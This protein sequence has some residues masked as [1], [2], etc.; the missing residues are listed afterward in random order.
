MSDYITIQTVG[1]DSEDKVLSYINARYLEKF[2]TVPPKSHTYIWARDHEEKVRGVIALD[3]ANKEGRVPIEE[4]YV[5][6]Y[7]SMERQTT[8]HDGVQFGRWLAEKEPSGVSMMLLYAAVCHAK[9]AGKRYGWV[10]HNDAVHRVLTRQGITFY[11]LPDAKLC[12]EKV[13]ELNR[14]YYL[15]PPLMKPYVM[16]LTEAEQVL[17]GTMTSPNCPAIFL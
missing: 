12:I 16:D 10:E 1:S 9:K 15:T 14:K 17:Q 11:P 4:L 13:A 6:D 7:A 2:G 8:G 3:Y 5:F